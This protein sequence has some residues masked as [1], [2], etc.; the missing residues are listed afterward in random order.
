M[1]NVAADLTR[2][3]GLVKE[4]YGD[5]V[6]ELIPIQSKLQSIIKFAERNKTPGNFFSQPL[7]LQLEH[8]VTYADGDDGAFALNDAISSVV[9]HARVR[10][11]QMLLRSVI[12]YELLAAANTKDN[13][14]FENATKYIVQAMVDSM[15]KK[16]EVS[17]MYGANNIGVVSGAVTSAV[18][19]TD[20]EWAPGIYSGAKDMKVDIF[21]AAKSV[22]RGTFVISGVDFDLKKI[23]MTTDAA[24]AGVVATDVVLPAGAY[25]IGGSSAG[26]EMVGLHEILSNSGTLFEINAS[27][28]ELWKGNVYNAGGELTFEKLIKAMARPAE[29]GLEKD[30]VAIVNPKTWSSL[31]KDQAALRRFD[32]SYSTKKL[33]N[34]TMAI[35]FYCQSGKIEVQS[36]IYCKQSYAYIFCVEDMKRIGSTDITFQLPGLPDNFLTQAPNNAG[37]E[38]RCYVN[39]ALFCRAPGKTLLITGIT[40]P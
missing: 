15:S 19:I 26:K 23:T 2:L 28:Y 25:Q 6:I 22:L 27:Q 17:L 40:H 20:A 16:H 31:M 37:Y 11:S 3:N 29:K 4:V 36:S 24:A 13:R 32:S 5:S 14:S 9:K 7:A 34:G 21:D 18:T 1:A 30:V 12:A 35:E 33:E 38:L 8:G 10:G 39:S